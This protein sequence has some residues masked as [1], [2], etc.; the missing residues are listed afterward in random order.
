MKDNDLIWESY[1]STKTHIFY[2]VQDARRNELD[3]ISKTRTPDSHSGVLLCTVKEAVPLVWMSWLGGVPADV[4]EVT[5]QIYKDTIENWEVPSFM[6]DYVTQFPKVFQQIQT[7]EGYD[8]KFRCPWI[9]PT[10]PPIKIATLKYND[11]LKI[12]GGMYKYFK[13][14]I[15]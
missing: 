6:V 15:L 2:R 7:T 13:E 3:Y 11:S 10:T 9:I 4:Y 5:G 8:C 1:T 12:G 14:H